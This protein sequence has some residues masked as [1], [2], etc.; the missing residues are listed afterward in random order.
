[1][2]S[3]VGRLPSAPS[4]D[5]FPSLFGHFA[6]TTRPCDSLPTFML[7][8]WFVTFSNRPAH[9]FVSG[10]GR[11]S[12][13]SCVEFPYMRGSLTSQ[14]PMN[15]RLLASTDVA[16]R[17]HGRRRHSDFLTCRVS[18]P[19]LHVLLSTLRFQPCDR[20]CMTRRRCGSLGLH[21]MALSSTP[22]R[23]FIPAHP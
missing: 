20:K 14:S 13:F 8:L 2:F 18:I 10:V 9:N 23:R 19:R 4:A 22:P 1:V 11:A 5:G 15:A 21:R 16:F 7:D 6:G 3:L 12:R 17:H